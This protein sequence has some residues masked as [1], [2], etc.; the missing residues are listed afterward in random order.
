MKKVILSILLIT[1]V[2]AFSGLNA[3]G[4]KTNIS[5][6]PLWGPVGYRYVEY[7]YL[8]GGDV[9]YDVLNSNFYYYSEGAWLFASKLPPA[10]SCELYPNYKVVINKPKPWLRHKNYFVKYV[11]YKSVRNLQTNIKDS[12]DQKYNV[13][14][15]HKNYKQENIA[16][17]ETGK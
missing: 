5:A 4:G 13:V 9:Y 15:G 14:K 16:T 10:Y 11:D 7:Y 6:Q 17:Q 8:P 12:N 2:L 1:N 3:Q